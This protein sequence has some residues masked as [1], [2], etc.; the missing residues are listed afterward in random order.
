MSTVRITLNINPTIRVDGAYVKAGA[1]VSAELS[2]S[3]MGDG[4]KYLRRLLRNSY[5]TALAEELHIIRKL[6]GA[7]MSGALKFIKTEKTDGEGNPSRTKKK[8]K[9]S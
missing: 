8:T 9:A 1:S 5:R 3:A 6:D 7:V 4:L 2:P